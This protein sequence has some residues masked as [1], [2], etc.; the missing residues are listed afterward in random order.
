MGCLSVGLVAAIGFILVIY[1]LASLHGM[2]TEYQ[3]SFASW[4]QIEGTEIVEEAPLSDPTFVFGNEITLHG[5]TADIAILGGDATLYGIYTGNVSF[6]G[7][8][9]DLA[10]DARIEGNLTLRGARH[11]TIQGVVQGEL[12]GHSDRLFQRPANENETPHPA[13]P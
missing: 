13:S 5:S 3:Q 11:A 2:V 12:E 9:F 1:E 4:T 6:L 7:R 8:H 10:T